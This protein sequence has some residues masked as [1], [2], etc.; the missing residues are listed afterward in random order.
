MSN[1]LARSGQIALYRQNTI[2]LSD[3]QE[4]ALG[5]D[6]NGN[7]YVNDVG[8]QEALVNGVEYD[9]IGIMPM[10]RSDAY[11]AIASTANA[12]TAQVVKA[13][14]T[15]KS[16]YITDIVIS[17]DTAG[18]VLIQDTAGTPNVIIGKKYLPANS[19]WSKTYVIPKQV[20]NGNGVNVL[21]QN[22]GN[23]SIDMNGYAI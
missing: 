12:T 2:T 19:V 17:T 8:Q 21:A 23:I 22:A 6:T 4:A 14:V 7:L 5:L 13:A 1:I 10:R 3:N 18:W 16:I 11:E 20:A 9:S 15:N